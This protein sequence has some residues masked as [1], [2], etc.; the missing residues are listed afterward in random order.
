MVVKNY[1]ELFDDQNLNDKPEEVTPVDKV[2]D[3]AP[4]D[5]VQEPI[6]EIIREL[7]TVKEEESIEEQ[8]KSFLREHLRDDDDMTYDT[9]ELDHWV[10]TRKLHESDSDK[11]SVKEPLLSTLTM[12]NE[13]PQ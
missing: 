11:D 13:V 10:F 3:F 6:T 12:P 9:A 2:Q 1:N 8:A 5:K 4:V 7:P